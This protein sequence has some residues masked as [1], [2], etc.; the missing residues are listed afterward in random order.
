MIIAQFCFKCNGV[1][2]T[3]DQSSRENKE[4]PSLTGDCLSTGNPYS[5]EDGITTSLNPALHTAATPHTSS[6]SPRWRVLHTFEQ[7]YWRL[8][9][10]SPQVYPF[11]AFERGLSLNGSQLRRVRV[12]SLLLYP[13]WVHRESVIRLILTLFSLK[14]HHKILAQTKPIRTISTT[15]QRR[16]I[17]VV[18]YGGGF[19]HVGALFGTGVV[20]R[21][22][23]KNPQALLKLHQ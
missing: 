10:T 18:R 7:K 19:G 14:V 2:S 23:L 6:H 13:D 17:V 4:R 5:L 15:N 3:P 22:H 16:L 20:W 8:S 1:Q 11:R 12:A 21:G 9:V